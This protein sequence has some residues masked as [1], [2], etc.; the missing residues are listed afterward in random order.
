[1]KTK[2]RE[3][4]ARYLVSLRTHLRRRNAKA[5]DLAPRL[6]RAAVVRG[7]ATL[8]LARMHE[9]AVATLGAAYDFASP[10]SPAL[11]R[12]RAFFHQALLPLEVDRRAVR[13]TN[14]HLIQRVETL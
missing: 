1:M 8:D 9:D 12:A 2:R 13:E 11:K 14:Q 4:S 7:L 3:L 6:G 5:S 10:R